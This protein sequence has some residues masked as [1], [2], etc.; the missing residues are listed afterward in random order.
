MASVVRPPSAPVGLPAG[1][2][3]F[4]GRQDE[5][6]QVRRLLATGRLV[7]L[8]G[9]GGCG[10]TRLALGVA[11]EWRR[12]SRRPAV[13]VGLASLTDGSLLE[14][15]VAEAL[16]IRDHSDRDL[17]EIVLDYLR[18]RDC[19]LVLDNCEHVRDACARLV[20]RALSTAPRLTVLGTSRPPLGRACE[21][22]FAAPP[23]PVPRPESEIG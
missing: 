11:E 14:Y 20:R 19:L 6:A 10:K 17:P 23:L 13:W 9:V 22:V 2:T 8:T 16:G 4:I 5:I 3:T 21:R 1:V 7:M 12:A 15:Q 18:A